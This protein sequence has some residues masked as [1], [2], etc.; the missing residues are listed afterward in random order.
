MKSLWTDALDLVKKS[1]VESVTLRY[2]SANGAL[3]DAVAPI[4]ALTEVS[5]ENGIKLEN[6]AVVYPNPNT[7]ILNPFLEKPAISFVCQLQV[8]LAT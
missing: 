5:L 2:V 6:G 8:R 1:G 4:D 7:A 3:I